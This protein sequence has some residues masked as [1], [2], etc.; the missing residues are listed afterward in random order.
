MPHDMYPKLAAKW[1]TLLYFCSAFIDL[2]IKKPGISESTKIIM[3]LIF[4]N[5]ATTRSCYNLVVYEFNPHG[6][7]LGFDAT[8]WGKIDGYRVITYFPVLLFALVFH[9]TLG[10]LLESYGSAPAIWKMWMRY[11]FAEKKKAKKKIL[12]QDEAERMRELQPLDALN[13]ETTED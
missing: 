12:M 2:I 10:M 3:S 5:L 8:L 11:V 6:T 7:G 13:F 1:G 9:F 4:P